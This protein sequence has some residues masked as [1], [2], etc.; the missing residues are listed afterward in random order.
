MA[1]RYSKG[2]ILH[3]LEAIL[4]SREFSNAER[5]SSFLRY[6]VE[7]SIEGRRE[8][9]KESVIGAEV[10]GRPAGYDPKVEPIVR[11]EAR[12]LRARIDEY[13]S[14]QDRWYRI[15]ISIPKGGYAAVF[16]DGNRPEAVVV[17]DREPAAPAASEA[18]PL[19]SHSRRADWISRTAAGAALLLAVFG[20]WRFRPTNPR[21]IPIITTLTSYPG[22][23]EFP[24]LS[25]DGTEVAFAWTSDEHPIR[26]IYVA[27]VRGGDPQAL[28]SGPG[29]DSFP[30]WSPDG[31]QIAY[32][33]DN[34]WLMLVGRRGGGERQL[35]EG[36]SA[37]VSWSPDGHWIAHSGWTADRKG[38]AIFETDPVT[39]RSRQMTFP[40]GDRDTDVS[41]AVSP[42][43]RRLAFIRCGEGAHGCAAYIMPSDGGAPR[44]VAADLGLTYGLAWSP[45]GRE[46][47]IA[48]RR[49][50]YS[51]L[52]RVDVSGAQPVDAIP[53]AGDDVHWVKLGHGSGRVVYQQDLRDSDIWRLD[54]GPDGKFGEARRLIASTRLDSSPQF[55][56]DGRSIVFDSD[57]TGYYEL[58]R[59][60]ADGR[61]ET[62]LTRL[63]MQGV[64]SPRWSPDGTRI[65]FD[66]HSTEGRAIYVMAAT[67]GAPIQWTKAR[68]ASRPSWSRDGKSIYY[69]DTDSGGVD[70]NQIYKVPAEEALRAPRQ[71]T[72]DGG[73]EA[74][75]SPDGKTLYYIRGQQLRRMPSEGGVS[76]LVFD[77]Q[78]THGWWSVTS[79]GIFFAD[80]S[81]HDLQGVFINKGH[82]PVYR[83]D[84]VSGAV[85]QVAEIDGNIFWQTP[86]FCVSPDGRTLLY[87]RLEIAVAQVRMMEGL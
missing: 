52:W 73:G 74:Y 55:S 8:C 79:A 65:A 59:A 7:N 58:W 63:R 2:E 3:E 62:P 40:Q 32:I 49:A 41:T 83:W 67:G 23:Q 45:S 16:E 46:L 28:T 1:V 60:D 14:R 11:T 53:I 68:A 22:R 4:T 86:D 29:G 47:L 51:Q 9:L 6:V 64:G 21:P 71:M 13:Y 44:T 42:D 50:G 24:A 18:P 69:Y 81:K 77:R 87:S 17:A 12:R 72:T 31:S 19:P 57:R 56:P 20:V 76:S 5:L 10:F 75:E 39:G 33:R 35:S 37:S 85:E 48:W 84:P 26:H 54:A 15:R 66:V 82:K 30:E 80:I 61:N 70:I 43:G 78:V 25:P 34:R 36:Y 27:P 38:L